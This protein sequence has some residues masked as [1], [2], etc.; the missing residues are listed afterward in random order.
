MNTF[1]KKPQN[2]YRNTTNL[3]KAKHAVILDKIV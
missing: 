1:N 2:M 3:Q